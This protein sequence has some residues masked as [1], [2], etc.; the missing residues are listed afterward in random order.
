[1]FSSNSRAH[2]VYEKAGYKETGRIPKAVTKGE[3]RID[4]INMFKEI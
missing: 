3:A 4:L 1:V 2:H